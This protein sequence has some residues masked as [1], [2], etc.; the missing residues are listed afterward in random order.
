M[1]LLEEMRSVVGVVLLL[2]V[3]I[4]LMMLAACGSDDAAPVV[5][6]KD[7]FVGSYNITASTF[8]DANTFV[9]DHDGDAST[10]CVPIPFG[11]GQPGGENALLFVLAGLF[12]PPAPACDPF[13]SAAIELRQDDTSWLFCPTDETIAAVQQ[14]SWSYDD[15]NN[16]ISIRLLLQ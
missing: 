9:V 12:N 11:P 8:V 1:K 10:A 4:G 7:Q 3:G 5:D 14:G 6:P 15:M 13:A 2:A 16:E